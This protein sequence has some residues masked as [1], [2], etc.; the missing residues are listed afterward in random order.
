MADELLENESFI[1]TLK[2]MISGEFTKFK[3]EFHNELPSLLETHVGQKLDSLTTR[4]VELEQTVK[5]DDIKNKIVQIEKDLSDTSAI[6]ESIKTDAL[7]SLISHFNQV[8]NS[9]SLTVLNGE[10]NRR[11]YALVIQGIKGPKGEDAKDTRK[12]L[13]NS[14]K[15]LLG[16]ESSVSDFA[17]CHRLNFNEADTGIHARFVDLS[18]RDLWLANAKK[19]AKVKKEDSISI[20]VDVPPCLRKVKKELNDMRMKL[21]PESKKRSYVKHLPSWPYFQLVER[22]DGKTQ[23]ITKHSFSKYD[24]AL[25]SLNDLKDQIDTLEYSLPALPL[26]PP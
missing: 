9:L 18:T 11:K 4:V 24:I 25:A 8:V 13:M 16:I 10:V 5:S 15:S 19:L 21:S 7:P 6:T 17:A 14:A 20:S 3:A 23:R 26:V 22:L 2:N 12:K 1:S